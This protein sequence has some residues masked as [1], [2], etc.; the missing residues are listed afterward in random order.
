[1]VNGGNMKRSLPIHI[2]LLITTVFAFSASARTLITPFGRP[3]VADYKS[4]DG[5]VYTYYC[6]V[7]GQSMG[8]AIEGP[9]QVG[10]LKP[11]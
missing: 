9:V 10:C 4:T 3:R 5:K 6:L 8:F 11:E 2:L 1:M 7:K